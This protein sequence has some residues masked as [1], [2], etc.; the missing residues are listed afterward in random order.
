MPL[1]L[2]PPITYL[3]TG[4]KTTPQ[5]TRRSKEFSLILDQIHTAIAAEI[6]LVQIREKQLAARVLYELVV[7]AMALARE[8]STRLLVNDRVD[9]ALSAH[10]DGVQLTSES[11]PAAVVRKIA[12]KQFMIGVSTHSVAEASAAQQGG[13]DFAVFG[14]VFETESKRAF[15]PPQGVDKLAEV[16]TRLGDFPVVAIGGI[17]VENSAECFRAGASGVAAIGLFED[18]KT[19]PTTVEAILRTYDCE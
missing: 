10:A 1:E 12:G 5:T 14:P 11:M 19:L 3:I 2:T 15:G 13:A 16:T 9:I 18:G 4:G 17:T 8:S 7:E 6:S